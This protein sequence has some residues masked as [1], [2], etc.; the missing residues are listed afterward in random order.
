MTAWIKCSERMPEIV[1]RNGG[2]ACSLSVLAVR[3]QWRFIGTWVSR[4][5]DGKRVEGFAVDDG[6]DPGLVRDATHWQP[7]P[8]PPKP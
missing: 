7:L 1:S 4:I 8:E 6:E 2:F 5:S 3:G